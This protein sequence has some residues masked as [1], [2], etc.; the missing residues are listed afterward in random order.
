MA[1]ITIATCQFLVHKQPELNLRSI[2]RQMKQAKAAG[3]HL[4]HFSECCLSGYLG[5]E[6]KSLREVDWNNLKSCMEQVM[7]WS[8]K[9]KIWAV[10]G[11]N[12]R[13]VGRHKPHNSLYVVNDNGELVTRY[14]KMFCTGN[15]IR[16]D[17]LKFY[18]PGEK[19]ITFCVKGVTCGLLICHDFRYPEL[20]REYKR[21]G[22]ELMLVSF[23]NA[24]MTCKLYNHY[25]I[26]VPAT[27]QAAAASNYFFVSAS[28]STR[29][30]AWP[31][32]VVNPEG[33]IIQKARAHRPAVIITKIDTKEKLYDASSHWRNRCMHGIF[34]SGKLVKDPRSQDRTIL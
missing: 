20:F 24:G 13:L 22:V 14:D 21:R 12:H 3:A 1:K 5:G 32:F 23:H 17:D 34:H 11:C 25:I 30:Y 6:I 4:A 19:F 18:S 10:V 29:R 27:L 7:S 9:L 28:N 8:G 26:S 33:R 2:I 15:N 31:G 16:S